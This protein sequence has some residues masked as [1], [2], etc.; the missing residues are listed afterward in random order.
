LIREIV[1]LQGTH[2]GSLIADLRFHH[3]WEGVHR[4]CPWATVFQGVPYLSRWYAL[5]SQ[6][7]EPVIA[8]GRDSAGDLAGLLCLGV[9][10]RSGKLVVAGTPHSEYTA[11]LARPEANDPFIEGALDRL[12]AQFPGRRLG[13]P[14]LPPETPLG[15]L[16]RGRKWS[17]LCDL[18]SLSRPI[19]AVGD[20]SK[21]RESLQKKSNR[22]HLRQLEKRGILEFQRIRRFDD[23]AEDFAEILDLHDFRQGAMY[24]GIPFRADPSK[25]AFLRSLYDVPNLLHTTVWRLGGRIISARIGFLDRS[26]GQVSLGY[27]VHSPFLAKHSPGRLHVYLL[28]LLLTQEGVATLDLTAGGDEYKDRFA[29]HHDEVHRLTVFFSGASRLGVSAQAAVRR[30]AKRALRLISVTPDDVRRQFDRVRSVKHHLIG[31]LG[32][33]TSGAQPKSNRTIYHLDRAYI[34]E[35][36]SDLPILRRDHLA[37]LLSYERSG[38]RTPSKEEF[39]RDAWERFERGDHIYTYRESGLLIF[40]VWVTRVFEP[41]GQDKEKHAVRLAASPVLIEEITR[42]ARQRDRGLFRAA[43]ARILTDLASSGDQSPVRVAV[44]GN[45]LTVREVLV[46]LGFGDRP[47]PASG[48]SRKG[49]E[50]SSIPDASLTESKLSALSS[51]QCRPHP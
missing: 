33:L 28:G 13:F 48:T 19:M 10:Q 24:G 20:G 2:A 18:R 50:M 23:I 17:R 39:L 4:R 9:E 16:A 38:R 41:A 43:L 21:I 34:V 44:D 45:D 7:F 27:L 32:G 8:L 22:Q 51:A 31:T 6:Q 37:D 30:T 1:V 12:G 11:W 3:E 40:H 26:G 49:V 14:C 15:W 25:G 46:Q 35:D 36:L 42:P 5:Y 29:T 47:S